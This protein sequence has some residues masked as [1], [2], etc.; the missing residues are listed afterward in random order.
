MYCV[1]QD[2]IYDW[3][4][5]LRHVRQ[6]LMYSCEPQWF[7]CKQDVPSRVVCSHDSRA[8]PDPELE[9]PAGPFVE[10]NVTG[11]HPPDQSSHAR[12]VGLPLLEGDDMTRHGVI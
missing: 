12:Q 2:M 8:Y 3:R 5:R 4:G 1:I 9:P 6:L 10:A 11:T 7:A